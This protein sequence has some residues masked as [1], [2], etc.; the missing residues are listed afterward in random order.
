MDAAG[1]EQA[2]PRSYAVVIGGGRGIGEA[3][4]R[5]LAAD[6]H[7]VIIADHLQKLAKALAYEMK[8]TG[9]EAYW[10]KVDITSQED[11]KKLADAIRKRAGASGL[12][13]AV[14]SVG[15]FDERRS[16]L[17][18]K[19]ESFQRVINTNI[20]G[21]LLFSQAVEP[22]LGP[23]ASLIH[24]GSINGFV[25]GADLG[26]Y[27]VS[28]A[29][30][31][32]MARC[33]ALELAP[34]PRHIRV[35]VI[36]PGWVDTPGERLALHRQWGH[37]HALEDPETAKWIPLGRR[38]DASEIASVVSFLCSEQGAAITGQIIPVDC[39]ISVGS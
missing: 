34:T 12:N 15:V 30:L 36:A 10:E 18:T 11:L 23:N 5:R 19:P 21:A 8:E 28:K 2:K 14:N 17:K 24:I 16:L 9:F 25:A 26:A 6:G 35:N 37:P 32:M 13:V 7:A 1:N 22:L 27:K 31:H 3:V 33:L 29:A 39:G 20:V 38:A 4:V